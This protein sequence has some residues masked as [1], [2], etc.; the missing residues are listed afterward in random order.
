[1]SSDARA[2]AVRLIVETLDLYPN[3]RVDYRSCWANLTDAVA[4]FDPDAAAILR[5]PDGDIGALHDELL[6]REETAAAVPAPAAGEREEIPAGMEGPLPD[7][8]GYEQ[9]PINC[10]TFACSHDPS[11]VCLRCR[12]TE[13]APPPRPAQDAVREAAETISRI[14][15]EI[16]AEEVGEDWVRAEFKRRFAAARAAQGGAEVTAPEPLP[17]PVCGR[18]PSVSVREAAETLEP[19]DTIKVACG[20][21]DKADVAR[22]IG[23]ARV[24][25]DAALRANAS[26]APGSAE[27]REAAEVVR[28]ILTAHDARLSESGVLTYG[29][30]SKGT[31]FVAAIQWLRRY[32]AAR[33]GE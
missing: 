19:I 21:A 4:C 29:P 16:A 30:P 6:A 15:F 24:A 12:D 32:D 1:V 25:L 9:P 27:V 17:C 26:P 14:Y 10:G 8:D 13:P 5:D 11:L 7:E 3:Y 28:T 2:K 20:T 22:R 23:R 33:G 18:Q 31:G